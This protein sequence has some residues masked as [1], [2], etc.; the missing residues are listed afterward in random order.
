MYGD[1]KQQTNEIAHWKTLTWPQIENFNRKTEYFHTAAQ[2]NAIKV[3]YL[4]AKI[5]KILRNSKCKLDGVKNETFHRRI[6]GCFILA[7]NEFKS[8][9][10]WVVNV[11]Q[12]ELCK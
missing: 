2:N 7:Q 12:C 10:V 9:Y 1:F 6:S 8:R 4:H 11:I 5:D 3:N